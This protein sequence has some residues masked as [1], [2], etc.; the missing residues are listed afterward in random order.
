MVAWGSSDRENSY[1]GDVSDF[2]FARPGEIV[3][4]D[5]EM[6]WRDLL[7]GARGGLC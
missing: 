2:C 3:A 4:L 6:V 1:T 5:E 7:R